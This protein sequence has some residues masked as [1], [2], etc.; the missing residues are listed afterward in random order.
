MAQSKEVIEERLMKEM[1]TKICTELKNG[2]KDD[3]HLETS[4][5]GGHLPP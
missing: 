5:G 4:H 1:F 2:N 3:K